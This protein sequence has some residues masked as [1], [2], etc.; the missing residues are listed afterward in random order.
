MGKSPRLGYNIGA[1]KPV[2][3]RIYEVQMPPKPHPDSRPV[4]YPR[5][6]NR[7][8]FIRLTK[9][10]YN[11]PPHKRRYYCILCTKDW[12]SSGWAKTYGREK[13]IRKFIENIP[14]MLR[15]DVQPLSVWTAI[16]FD[17]YSATD[18]ENKSEITVGGV[19][20][21]ELDAVQPSASVDI[22]TERMRKEFWLNYDRWY[23]AMEDKWEHRQAI[24]IKQ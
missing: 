14:P 15:V 2:P 13:S 4:P 9:D 24:H 5:K 6:C 20:W 11:E 10:W 22:S 1:G 8:G 3:I 19:M 17:L 7:C 12:N 18:R 16:G 21:Y 23:S